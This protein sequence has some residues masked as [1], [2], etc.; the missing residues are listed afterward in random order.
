MDVGK[1]IR[2]LRD[3]RGMEQREL[4]E[5]I[6]VS[7]SKMNK[8]ET[9][10]QKRIEPEIL[11]DLSKT[12]DATVDYIVGNSHHPHLTEEESFE[13]FIKDPEL[14]RWYKEMPKSGEENIRKLRKIWEAFKDD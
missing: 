13:A 4:A 7:Q 8:I 9:G 10:F 12:L 3:N 11:V 5:K 14:I 6:G 1:R 2:D